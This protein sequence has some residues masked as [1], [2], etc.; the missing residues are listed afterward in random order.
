[1]HLLHA[2]ALSLYLYSTYGTRL[3]GSPDIRPRVDDLLPVGTGRVDTFSSTIRWRELYQSLSLERERE[4]RE[5]GR[6]EREQRE[7]IPEVSSN[8]E[9]P[10]KKI[11]T[12]SNLKK[13][14]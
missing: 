9:P 10:I 13:D 5:R 14:P 12:N 6:D 4:R 7:Y 3:R 11:V 2:S 8:S 1:L